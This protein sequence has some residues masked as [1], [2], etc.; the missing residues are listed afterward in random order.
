VHVAILR[1]DRTQLTL[2]SFGLSI[3]EFEALTSHIL[4]FND[5]PDLM[6]R[7]REQADARVREFERRMLETQE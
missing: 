4:T 6:L 7:Y 2:S 1:N 5:R 3:D